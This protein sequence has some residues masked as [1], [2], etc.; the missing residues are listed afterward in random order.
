VLAIALVR[1]NV[2]A[3]WATALLAVGTLATVAAGMVPQYERLFAIPTAVA[4]I[5]LG[6]SLWRGQRTPIAAAA[7]SPGSSHLGAGG[8]K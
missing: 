5:G 6:Y 3:R 1:A 7:L 4:F 2:L 8:A